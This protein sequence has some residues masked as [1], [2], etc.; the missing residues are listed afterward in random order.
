MAIERRTAALR[1]PL[2]YTTRCRV[3]EVID[4]DTLEVEIVKRVRVRLLDCW[5]PESRTRDKTEKEKGLAARNHLDYL[6]AGKDGVLFVP[7]HQEN[8]VGDA[9]TLSRVLGQVWIDGQRSSLAEQQ[10]ENKLA[11][12]RKGAALGR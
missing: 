8:E 1:P 7:G 3:V 10:V 9:L 12:T 5:A 11:S 2:G 6:A 4:G